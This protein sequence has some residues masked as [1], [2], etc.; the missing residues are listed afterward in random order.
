MG[1]GSPRHMFAVCTQDGAGH[2]TQGEKEAGRNESQAPHDAHSPR[3]ASESI[4]R[5]SEAMRGFS[6]VQA[7]RL[8]DSS[9]VRAL[10]DRS[11]TL[12]G[13]DL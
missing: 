13:A 8:P 10:G 1:W 3:R 9:A 6:L 11:G 4:G 2:F 7:I 12:Q 5:H